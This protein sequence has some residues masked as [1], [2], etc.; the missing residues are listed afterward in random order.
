M[1]M[2]R[3]KVRM[4]VSDENDEPDESDNRALRCENALTRK[5]IICEQLKKREYF[6]N[7]NLIFMCEKPKRNTKPSGERTE[8]GRNPSKKV[9]T[10]TTASGL[11][12]W[13]VFTESS[14]RSSSWS[15]C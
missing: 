5:T 2:G 7:P 1:K 14:S 10:A 9:Y 11:F 15:C 3:M 12:F 8:T 6:N 13:I 4:R